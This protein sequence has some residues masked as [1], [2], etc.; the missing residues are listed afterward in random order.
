MAKKKILDIL[1]DPDISDKEKR[2]A[3]EKWKFNQL[4]DWYRKEHAK[5]YKEKIKQLASALVDLVI[6]EQ[7]HK[8]L[9]SVEE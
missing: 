2:I 1:R 6:E 8:L 3:T 4:P 5:E 7:G 9:K